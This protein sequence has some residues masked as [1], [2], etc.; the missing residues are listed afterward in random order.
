MLGQV[1]QGAGQAWGAWVLKCWG[2]SPAPHHHGT[3]TTGEGDA[4]Q[5]GVFHRVERTYVARPSSPHAVPTADRP[6][7]PLSRARAP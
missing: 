6:E 2:A 5:K 1:E 3:T 4:R 7:E